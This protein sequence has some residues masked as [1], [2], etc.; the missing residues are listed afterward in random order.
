MRVIP[1]IDLRGGR[2][3]RLLQ[4]DYDRET[5]YH[6]D[7]VALAERYAGAGADWLHVVDLDAARDGGEANLA[8]IRRIR[9]TVGLKL[10]AGGGVRTRGDLD[11]RLAVGID[12][13]VL[14]SLCV[15]SPETVA[16]WLAELGPDP[17]LAGLDVR[18]DPH[19]RWLPHACGWTEAGERDLFDL[20]A[21]LARAGLTGVLCTDI[22]RDGALQGPNTDLYATLVRRFP[23]VAVQASGGVGAAADLET[24]AA[25][26]AAACIVG[27]AL[28]EGGVS[29]AEIT[30]WSR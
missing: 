7:P 24:V 29:D 19:D 9:D 4:G 17:I 3:V 22:D 1:A 18:R 2:V 8:A 16:A 13:V 25:T 5:R 26:G 10:Q 27:R 11:R 23:G 14:G 15:K 21:E 30:R 6:D 20:L 12:R 28:L